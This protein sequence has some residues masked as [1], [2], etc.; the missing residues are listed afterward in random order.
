MFSWGSV[1]TDSWV[2]AKTFSS[3]VRR[4][5]LEKT[6]GSYNRHLEFIDPLPVVI[7]ENVWV[8]FEVIILPGVTIGKGAVIGCRTI[9]SE[10]V[11]EYAVVVGNPSRII[12]YLDANDTN[13]VKGNAIKQF[14]N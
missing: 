9:I 7:E 2:T 12:K 4:A 3:T 13:E 14:V 5:M 10:D 8:G 6:A 11:P 1:I